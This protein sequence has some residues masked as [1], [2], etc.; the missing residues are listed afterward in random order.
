MVLA[1]VSDSFQGTLDEIFAF[2]PN[3][4]GALFLLI[5]GW[6]VAKVVA[7]LVRRGLR[8][9][10]ADRALATGRAGEYRERFSPDLQP[11]GVIGTI[12]FWSLFALAIMLAVSALGVEALSDFMSAVVAYLP[13]VIAALLILLVAIAV[14]G[15]VG[16]IAQRLMGGTMLGRIVQTVVPT[17]VMTIA[18]FMALVQ[19]KIA[20]EIVVAT[21]VI[22][23][24]SIGLGFALAFG[25][26]GRR[27]ADELLFN[28]YE[29]GRQRMP[30]L[31]REAAVAKARAA[32]DVERLKSEAEQPPARAIGST[33]V[34][35]RT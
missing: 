26:G 11:S 30:E 13:N 32:A 25:L 8:S 29:S 19:L 12:V 21:Y 18:L 27:A 3:L 35:P 16:G 7:G 28:A 23:L 31:K 14:A 1:D 9:A 10:G 24:G 20:T 5:I 6:I 17:L 34:E 4:V 2:L 22:V 15:A 33:A